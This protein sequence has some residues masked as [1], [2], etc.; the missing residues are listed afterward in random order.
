MDDNRNLQKSQKMENQATSG[1]Q[2]SLQNIMMRKLDQHY[3]RT[4]DKI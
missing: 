4:L 3:R 1:H 2:D